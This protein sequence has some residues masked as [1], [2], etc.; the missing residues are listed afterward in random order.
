MCGINLVISKK[1]VEKKAIRDMQKATSYRGPDASGLKQVAENNWHLQVGVNRLMVIDQEE[2]SNQPMVSDCGRYLLAFNGE[3]YNYQDLKNKLLDTGCRFATHSDTEVVLYWLRKFGFDGLKELQGMFALALVDLDEKKVLLARDRHGIKPLY[4]YENSSQVIISSALEGIKASG[5]AELSINTRAI[6]HYLAFR[7]VWGCETMYKQVRSVGSGM[8]LLINDQLQTKERT[9]P[10][11][12]MESG[13][14]N[15]ALIDAVSHTLEAATTP[16]LLL[17]G[18]IDSTLL[19]AI[20]N[21]ELGIR[22]L[23]VYTFASHKEEVKW[24]KKMARR[25]QADHIIVEATEPVVDKIEEYLNLLDHP[26]ADHGGM[27]TWWVAQRAQANGNVLLSGSGADEL[28]AGYNRHRAMVVYLKNRRLLLRLKKLMGAIPV[29]K[30][31]P[32]AIAMLLNEVDT[33]TSTTFKNFL[34]IYG[35][36]KDNLKCNSFDTLNSP[37]HILQNILDFDKANYLVNDVLSI[38]DFAGMR[39]SVEIRVP[40][41]YEPVVQVANNI[42]AAIKYKHHGK[43][44]LKQLVGKYGARD[45][46]KRKKMGFGLPVADWFRDPKTRHLWQFMEKESPVFEYIEKSEA[47]TM[48]DEHLS[49]KKDFNMQL[50]SILVLQKW[51]ER[52]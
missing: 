19:L 42:G 26:V 6:D 51:L 17:S 39:A 2:A 46:A 7:H 23:P 48:L 9:I 5:L 10:E 38:T 25:Y 28:F 47:Q 4:I 49:S 21:K 16:G 45:V 50:W 27:A 18:G 30:G 33:E 24:A 41:L 40:Y 35:I 36:R 29:R 11:P 3:V 32:K 34:Q 37:K 1:P 13:N 43:W 52:H 22:G 15:E 14:L 12:R 8:T 31:L 20:V 44:P